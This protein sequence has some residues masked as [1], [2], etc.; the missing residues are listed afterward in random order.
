MNEK[1]RAEAVAHCRYVD[2]GRNIHNILVV[3]NSPWIVTPEFI[4]K[5]QIDFIV[6]GEDD[7]FDEDGNDCNH[8]FN[9]GYQGT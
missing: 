7:A 2:E 8:F 9:K 3:L 1:E 4:E 6:H 5:Y